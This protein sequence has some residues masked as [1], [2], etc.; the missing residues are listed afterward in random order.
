MF[1]TGSSLRVVAATIIATA[2]IAACGS[3]S[4]TSRDVPTPGGRPNQ[5]LTE[6]HAVAF[7]ACMRSRG[8]RGFP[9]PATPAFKLALAPSSAHSPGFL[10][11]YAVCRHLLPDDG[12]PGPGPPPDPGQ[13][14]AFVAFARCLRGHGFPSFPDPTSTG[15]LT[16][17]MIANAG[18]NLNQPATLQAADACVGVTHGVI[19]KVD[20][21]RFVAG[22]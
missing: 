22:Q 16:H 15:Q 4:P 8:L 18:I 1:S 14:A 7:S 3:D 5:A 17:Q 10:S 12:V 20:V 11:A 13:I 19:T 21:A 2:L 6:Q 9:D